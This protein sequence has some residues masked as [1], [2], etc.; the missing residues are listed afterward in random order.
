MKVR[1]AVTLCAA[2]LLTSPAAAQTVSSSQVET[3]P[4]FT[5]AQVSTHARSA[6][7]I[8]T[9][10]ELAGPPTISTALRQAASQGVSPESTAWR[11]KVDA[12][13]ARRSRN[14]KLIWIGAG[15]A[16]A[17]PLFFRSTTLMGLMGI[18]GAGVMGY[19]IYNGSKIADEYEGLML[20]GRQRGYVSFSP[21]RD[22]ARIA[23]S[24]SF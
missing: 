8:V 1:I 15:A 11:A 17:S 16:A 12:N 9:G 24:F 4:V 7:D 21:T 3:P 23:L 5:S 6:T 14:S 10:F 18:G 13:R 22:G 2:C 20:D 19:G